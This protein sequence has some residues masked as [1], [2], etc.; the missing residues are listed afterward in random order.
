MIS[1]IVGL[2]HPG[3]GEMIPRLFEPLGAGAH[4]PPACEWWEAAGDTALG[5]LGARSPNVADCG[6]VLAVMDGFI[7]NRDELG[8]GDTDAELLVS[9]YLQYGFEGALSRINGDFAAALLDQDRGVLWLGRDRLGIRPLYFAAKEGLFAFASRPR[10][11]L[12]LPGVSR[13]TRREFLAL[14]AASHYRTFDNDPEMSPYEDV[15]QV[16]AGHVLS[17]QAGTVSLK[18]YWRLEDLPEWEEPEEEL[19]GRYR[20]LILDAVARRLKVAPSAAFTLS[21]G[22]DSST[23]LA[24]AARLAG[25]RQRAV[26]T[27]YDDKTYDESTDIKDMLEAAASEWIPVRV[28]EPDLAALVRMMVVAH[29][30]PV[31]T[32]TW[33]SHFLLCGVARQS[34]IGTLFGGL[35]GDEL[36][37]GEYEYFFFFFADLQSAGLE[38]LLKKETE[39]WI[40]QHD[41]PVFRKSV[42]VMREGLKRLV[43]L[44][45]PGRC[46]ADRGRIERYAAALKPDFF[47]LQG[48]EPV[49]ER[50]F[51]SYLKNRAYHDIFRETLPCCL[52]A[53]DRNGSALGV[54]H[55]M[56]FLDH[57]LVEFTFR[58]PA[59]LKIRDGVTKRL[60]REAMR[61]ILPEATRT[62]VKKTGWNA[63]AHRWFTGKG[64]ELVLDLVRSRESRERGIYDA[65]EVERLAQEHEEIVL[66]G[67]PADNHM[68]FLWQVLNLELWL[69]SLSPA[70]P[71][72]G[73]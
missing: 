38:A 63:P 9:L 1:R 57:R 37:A 70:G 21:G 47:R 33:L 49:M 16:P 6:K 35:G 46:L 64:K 8:G 17:L 11:L 29:D 61:G 62:R 69:R 31:A 40:V 68:M 43:D 65:V 71:S 60:L 56:P 26:S 32:A 12:A 19:A 45:T 54:A 72:A 3:A 66:S 10:P 15:R 34:R 52:R 51:T 28:G 73:P 2:S 5:W 25:G 41:H 24:C 4:F 39:A 48:F 14:F 22:M 13:E 53:A 20:E 18:R 27:V 42:S 23:V 7:Y 30:E 50:V 67:R 55:V 44:S 59:A 58:V 36:N